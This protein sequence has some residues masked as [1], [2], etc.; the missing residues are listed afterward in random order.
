MAIL[1]VG[2]GYPYTSI[3]TAIGDAT[4]ADIIEI[5]EDISEAGS[6]Q[7][8]VAGIR[9]SSGNKFTFTSTN[10]IFTNQEAGATPVSNLKLNGGLFFGFSISASNTAASYS[11]EN[12]DFLGAG[13]QATLRMSFTTG[14]VPSKI[15]FD[16]CLFDGAGT[17]SVP[18]I[19]GG[20][21]SSYGWSSD[22]VEIQNTIIKNYAGTV[23]QMMDADSN[24]SISAYR[25]TNCTFYNTGSS[26]LADAVNDYSIFTNCA[27][28]NAG[29]TCLNIADE[30]TQISYSALSQSTDF[31]GTS[32]QF[33]VD[34]TTAALNFTD[35]PNEDFTTPFTSVLVNAGTS[36]SLTEDYI[37][38]P[39][40]VDTVDIGAYE[41]QTPLIVVHYQ[42][43]YPTN[44]AALMESSNSVSLSWDPPE[45]A[46]GTVTG[47]RVY[48]SYTYDQIMH[49]LAF[50]T[51]TGYIDEDLE[52]GREYFYRVTTVFYD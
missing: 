1:Q 42:S 21:F 16:R 37:G 28:H 20:Y 9:S 8:T 34:F 25:L 15:T 30:A 17:T 46:Y 4:S 33:G 38:N 3:V 26:L 31:G 36:N 48:R 47:Y 13:I 40:P 32:N 35:G 49:P 10:F 2:T 6:I 45:E 52:Q 24:P 51:T 5:M 12:V 41:N 11:F 22:T 18:A 43:G 7:K 27:F 39:R 19:A 14:N 50:V 29:A 23:L 44:V